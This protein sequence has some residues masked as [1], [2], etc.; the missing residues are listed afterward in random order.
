[1]NQR[2]PGENEDHHIINPPML[3]DEVSSTEF[4]IGT[5]RRSSEEDDTKWRI[6]RIWQIGSVWRFG[7]P[8]G[9]QDF[10]YKWSERFGYTY[11]Q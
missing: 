1:M 8:N 10:K 3:I 7:Y 9:D 11:K 2:L 4:Y 5:S 6:K